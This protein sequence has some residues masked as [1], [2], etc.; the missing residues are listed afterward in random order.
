MIHY[1]EQNTD[2]WQAVRL[3]KLT[4][5]NASQIRVNGKGLETLCLKL[6]LEKITG[7]P[8]DKYEGNEHTERGHELEEIA[9]TVYEMEH[10]NTQKVGFVELDEYTGCS[11][12]RLVGDDGLLEIKCPSDK[13]M[14]EYLL[15]IKDPL[16]EYNDQIQMQMY[17]TDRKWCDLFLF[18]EELGTKRIRVERDEETIKKL[19]EGIK[20]GKSLINQYIEQ[21]ETNRI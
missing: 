3:G 2:E 12:D 9:V 11:P 7:K 4:A 18:N 19:K 16:K 21:Y 17:V 14:F 20:K 8:Q 6:A 13:V 1:F 15:K 10:E 5:S